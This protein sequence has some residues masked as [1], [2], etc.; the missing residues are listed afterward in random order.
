MQAQ[1]IAGYQRAGEA[2]GENCKRY[3]GL[4]PPALALKYT[5]RSVTVT[6]MQCTDDYIFNNWT[7]RKEGKELLLLSC[8]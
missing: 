4:S 2:E 3:W 7:E 1:H 8:S 5:H 6:Q